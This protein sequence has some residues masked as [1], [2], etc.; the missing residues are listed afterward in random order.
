M[1]IFS[2]KPPMVY[3]P[4]NMVDLWYVPTVTTHDVFTL[5]Y[6]PIF[7]RLCKPTEFEVEGWKKIISVEKCLNDFVPGAWKNLELNSRMIECNVFKGKGVSTK[8]YFF[9]NSNHVLRTRPAK[10]EKSQIFR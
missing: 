1:Q 7:D 4:Y 6:N 10:S 5:L 9:I 2:K 3:A 8:T